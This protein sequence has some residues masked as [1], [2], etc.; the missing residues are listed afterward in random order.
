MKQEILGSWPE[1][2]VADL[3]RMKRPIQLRGSW[4]KRGTLSASELENLY[5]DYFYKHRNVK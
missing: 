3:S 5:K 2:S 1:F 4:H